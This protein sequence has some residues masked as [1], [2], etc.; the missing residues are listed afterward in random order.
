MTFM[1]PGVCRLVIWVT[2]GRGVLLIVVRRQRSC[3]CI[4][5]SLGSGNAQL[6]KQG[7][8]NRH[9][10][11]ISSIC[12]LHHALLF[13][14]RHETRFNRACNFV[15]LKRGREGGYRKGSGPVVWRARLRRP[16]RTVVRGTQT[17]RAWRHVVTTRLKQALIDRTAS[18]PGLGLSE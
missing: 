18:I 7:V 17:G 8:N 2:T 1:V 3:R 6:A 5:I 15:A 11:Q 12:I 16:L 4:L 10:H 14:H 13:L 9:H